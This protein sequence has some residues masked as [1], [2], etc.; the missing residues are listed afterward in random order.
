[1]D[2]KREEKKKKPLHLMLSFDA[3]R[4]LRVLAAHH[5]LSMKDYI[6]TMVMREIKELKK[7]YV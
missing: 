6:E 4:Y 3:H 7:E 5:D 1:M 2:N